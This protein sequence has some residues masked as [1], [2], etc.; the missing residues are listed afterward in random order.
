MQ[1]RPRRRRQPRPCRGRRRLIG[2]S[3]CS[4]RRGTRCAGSSAPVTPGAG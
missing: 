2:C 1:R 3:L 4:G